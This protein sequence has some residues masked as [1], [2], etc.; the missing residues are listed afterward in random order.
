[1]AAGEAVGIAGGHGVKAKGAERKKLA[2]G[3]GFD[4]A[5]EHEVAD[6]LIK[7]PD[8]QRLAVGFV[9]HQVDGAQILQPI[10]Q[11]VRQASALL[12]RAVHR[13]EFFD[14]GDIELLADERQRVLSGSRP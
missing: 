5:V 1:M 6:Q 3:V 4:R 14:Y 13:G 2:L 11:R 10:G 12:F 9:T 8:I 7:G